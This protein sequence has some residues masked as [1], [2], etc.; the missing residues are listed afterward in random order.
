M[1]NRDELGSWLEGPPTSSD[2]DWPG[3]RLGRPESGRGAVA[4]IGRRLLALIIDWALCLLISYA[5]LGYHNGQ[6]GLTGFEPLLV[7]FVENLLLVGTLGTTMGHRIMGLRVTRL[8]G[9]MSNPLFIAAR[10]LLLCLVIP[11][12]V[13]DGDQRGLHD[14]LAGTIITRT[15]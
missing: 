8:D 6:S 12:A 5:L 14:R 4:S 3:Q 1:V 10:S 7:F 2:Q 13:W 11:A 15:R 9:T